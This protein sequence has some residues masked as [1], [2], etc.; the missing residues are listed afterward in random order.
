MGRGNLLQEIVLTFLPQFRHTLS[1]KLDRGMDGIFLVDS[2]CEKCGLSKTLSLSDGSLE[3]W[4][5]EHSCG[6]L[7]VIHSKTPLR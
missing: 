3:K 2:T 1:R 6:N 5:L 4:E 7:R